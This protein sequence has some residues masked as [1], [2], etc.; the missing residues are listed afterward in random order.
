MYLDVK[1]QLQV[2][3]VNFIIQRIKYYRKEEQ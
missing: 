3:G 1:N 2:H